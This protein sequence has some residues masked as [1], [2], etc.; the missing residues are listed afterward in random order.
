MVIIVSEER[1]AITVAHNGR[2]SIDITA[3]ELQRILSEDK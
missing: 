3:E 1:G 2:L